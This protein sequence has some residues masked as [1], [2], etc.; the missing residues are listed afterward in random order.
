MSDTR[1]GYFLCVRNEGYAASL[2]PRTVYAAL[3]DP[4]AESHGMLRIVDES[5]ED[6]LFPASLFVPI[7]VPE[8]AA[9]VFAGAA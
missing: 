5:G 8:V 7:D 2:Q 6:Y 9:K 4:D 1:R 3:C